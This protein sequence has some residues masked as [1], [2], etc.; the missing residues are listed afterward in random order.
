MASR[1]HH[2]V[3]LG[4]SIF[5][6]GSYVDRGQP[7]VIDQLKSKVKDQGWNATLVAVD[8]HVLSHVADQ[9]EKVPRDATHLFV[10]I[11][12]NKIHIYLFYLI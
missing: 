7:A 11:G 1:I 8:G 6:N 10:S 5:D 9:I 3:L 12:K 2:L 4:D